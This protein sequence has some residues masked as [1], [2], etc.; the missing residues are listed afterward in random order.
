MSIPNRIIES[1]LHLLLDIPGKVIGCHPTR[2]YVES[3]FTGIVVSVNDLKL[4]GV[5]GGPTRRCNQPALACRSDTVKTPTRAEN[6]IDEFEVVDSNVSGRVAACDP[7]GKLATTDCFRFKER[8]I[9]IVNMLESAIGNECPEGFVVRVGKLVIDDLGENARR[10]GNLEEVVEMS[11]VEDGGFF[12]EEMLAGREC[13]SGGLV[14]T[15]VWRRDANHI[16]WGG[17]EVAN[18]MSTSEALEQPSRGGGRLIS[19]SKGTITCPGGDRNKL[20]AHRASLDRKKRG[21]RNAFEE[22]AVGLVKDHPE[23]DHSGGEG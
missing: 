8:A 18:C 4:D 19:I 7:F 2:V 9:T 3:G 17:K 12:D 10:V 11:E 22:W 21:P 1:E 16:N 5:P 13:G 23:P 20:D 6:E 15:V 14:V